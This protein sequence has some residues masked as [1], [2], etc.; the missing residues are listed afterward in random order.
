MFPLWERS[1]FSFSFQLEKHNKIKGPSAPSVH[2]PSVGSGGLQ[3]VVLQ[4]LQLSTRAESTGTPKCASPMGD[5]GVSKVPW[6]HSTPTHL[7]SSQRLPYPSAA[8]SQRIKI[9]FKKESR[10][11]PSVFENGLFPYPAFGTASQLGHCTSPHNGHS[12]CSWGSH[13]GIEQ[14]MELPCSYFIFYLPFFFS[15]SFPLFYPFCT[16]T[17]W[18]PSRTS[19]QATS[20]SIYWQIIYLWTRREKR[21]NIQWRCVGRA[22]GDAAQT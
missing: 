7:M 4:G 2:L 18:G 1:L 14:P 8:C 3:S 6:G 19:G 20:G 16:T 12:C 11:N 17:P 10:F 21:P 5:H 15:L 13:A 22:F 9:S